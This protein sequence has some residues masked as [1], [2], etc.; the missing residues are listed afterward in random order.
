MSR[1]M[2]RATS[3]LVAAEVAL[4][5]VL[6][7]GA[8]LILRSFAALLSVDPGFQYESVL[9]TNI[10]LPAQRYA[11]PSARFGFFD[12]AFDELRQLPGVEDVGAAVVIPLTGNNWTVPFERADQP[13][14]PGERPPDVGWQTASGGFFRALQIPL[15]EGRLFDERDRGGAPAVVIVSS[16]IQQRFFPGESAV[17]RRVKLGENS[18]EIVGVVGDIRRAGL[19][20]EPRADMYFPF[21]TNLPGQ[22]T[23]FLRTSTDPAEL[24]DD[25]R[26]VLRAVEPNVALPS[27]QTFEGIAQESLGVTRLVLWLLGIFAGLALVLAAVGIYGVMSYVVRQRTREIGTRMAVGATRMDILWLVLRHGS[28]VA[29]VGMAAGLA[30]GLVA[31]RS[32]AS[33]LYGVTA[34]DPLTMLGAA[35]VLAAATLGACAIPALRAATVDP[36]RTL[37]QP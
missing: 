15:I 9:T 35:S 20:D 34:A 33:L 5:I 13:A 3:A 21:E 32:L 19:T 23:L 16:A 14:R 8:G 25:V 29:L 22:V 37:S 27:M 10:Q 30:A 24:G 26:G 18:A 28:V 12:R 1:M 11:Q 4:A 17:G 7:T 6:L 2:R 36:A 31:T